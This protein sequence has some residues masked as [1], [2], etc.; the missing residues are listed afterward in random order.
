M[1]LS[2]LFYTKSKKYNESIFLILKTGKSM[3]RSFFVSLSCLF[4]KPAAFHFKHQ[5]V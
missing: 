4:E 3:S 1:S 5:R 2:V